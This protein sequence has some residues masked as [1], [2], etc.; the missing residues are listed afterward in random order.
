MARLNARQFSTPC[1][2][3]GRQLNNEPGEGWVDREASL[4][5][6]DAMWRETCEASET[7]SAEHSPL[8]NN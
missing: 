6:D 2:G 4:N 8:I 3:C 5:S 1:I 7:F